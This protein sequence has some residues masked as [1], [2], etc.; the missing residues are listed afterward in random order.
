MNVYGL[1]LLGKP[2]VQLAA[3]TVLAAV[4]LV[5]RLIQFIHW[6]GEIQWGYDFSFYWTA[7][8]NLIDGRPIY[9]AQ[10]LG[11]PYVPQAQEGFLYPPPLA[12]V[13]MPLAAIFASDYRPAVWIWSGLGAIV[14]VGSVLALVRSEE[15]ALR[16]PILEGRGRWWLVAGA[17]AFP[18]VV[19]ELVVGNVHLF[20][21]GLLTLAWLGIRRE[22]Q[23]QAGLATG[24]AAAIK[25]FPGLLG[26]WY[27]LTRRWTAAI[28]TVIGALAIAIGSLP[29]TGLEPWLQYPV[30]LAN[31]SATPEAID[32]L[33]PTM[34][35]TP[36]LGF[37]I[38]RLLV[39]V[40]GLGI[41]VWVA[42]AGGTR[43]GFATTVVVSI[44]ATPALYTSYLSILVLPMLLGLAAGVRVRWVAVAYLLMWGG[45][46]AALGDLAWVVN[47]GLP[48]A[49][50]L[51]LLGL[52]V[53]RA[54][55]PT[56]D[57]PT[58]AEGTAAE[59]TAAQGMT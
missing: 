49:G 22:Q 5:Y 32:A 37:G 33:A 21:L 26:L 42:R 15:L 46:Q 47:K 44:L 56:G 25:I 51:L 27:V 8:S 23:R 31:L 24:A 29:F 7:A 57:Q 1:R 53:E 9:S 39:T 59:G 40:V 14:L 35:L 2:R 18:P 48:T 36:I 16:F 3:A 11:G 58:G 55:R 52:L 10:Q 45:Q 20:L 30:V 41:V 43:P 54:V 12:V 34:W 4:V 19:D 50:A 28:W 38:A 17:F 6:T 13:V